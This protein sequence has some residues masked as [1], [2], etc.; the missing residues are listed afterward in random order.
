[1]LFST[2]KIYFV[3]YLKCLDKSITI[4]RYQPI[5]HFEVSFISKRLTMKVVYFLAVI[6]ALFQASQGRNLS[7]KFPQR[8]NL[9]TPF[10]KRQRIETSPL[11]VGGSPAEIANFPHQLGLL[12][13]TVG[14]YICG[15]TNISPLWALSVAHCLEFDVPAHLVN[16]INDI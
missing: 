5:S 1:M 13:L 6:F 9:R 4:R 14:G 15:A 7:S 16:M 2:G 11:I 10:Y 12:D 8:F 3:D